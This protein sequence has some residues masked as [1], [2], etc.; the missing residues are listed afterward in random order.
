M[1]PQKKSHCTPEHWPLPQRKPCLMKLSDMR[2]VFTSSVCLPW[3][4]W[5]RDARPLRA[6]VISGQ[7]FL[8]CWETGRIRLDFEM[9]KVFKLEQFFESW[10]KWYFAILL[11]RAELSTDFKLKCRFTE[12]HCSVSG[13]IIKVT[14]QALIFTLPTFKIL[15]N[16]LYIAKFA[17]N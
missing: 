6:G 17:Y 12:L 14:K 4:P 15:R 5:P 11:Y 13:G 1:T 2:S 9:A 16:I 8:I 3:Q 10:R 7:L